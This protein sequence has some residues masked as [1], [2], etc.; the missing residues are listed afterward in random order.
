[1]KKGLLDF[2]DMLRKE[3]ELLEITRFVDPEL[4][5]A[6]ITD[7]ISKQPGGGKALFFTNTGTGYPLLIN[8]FGSERRICMALHLASLE[9]AGQRMEE[10][11]GIL[12]GQQKSFLGKLSLLPHL[13]EMSSWFPHFVKHRGA[14]QEIIWDVPDLYRLPVLKCW[15]NDAGRFI[16]LPVVH[17]YHPETRARNV[18]MYRMQVFSA[19]ATGMHWHRHKT[20]ATHYQAWK[21]KG[22]K[23]PVAVILGGDP[24]YTYVATAPLPEGIDEYLFAGFLRKQRVNL[25][26]CI[27]Q[28]IEVPEDAD[29]VIEGYV[30][31]MESLVPEGPFGDHTGFYS[32]QDFYPCFHVTAVTSRKEAV[33]PATVVGIPPQEDAWI[34]KA[35][36]RIFLKPI[37]IGLSPVI[38]DISLPSFGVAHNFAVVSIHKS[39]PG[40]AIKVANFLWGAGQMMLNKIMLVVDSKVNIHNEEEILAQLAS[41]VRIPEDFHFQMGPLDVLDHAASH[42][43]FGGKV[44]IDATTKMEEEFGIMSGKAIVSLEPGY[45]SDV[46]ELIRTSRVWQRGQLNVFMAAVRKRSGSI[47]ELASYLAQGHTPD[48]DL[49]ILLVDQEMNLTNIQS[50]L[51]YA[52]NNVDPERDFYFFKF[53]MGNVILVIDSTRKFKKTDNFERKWPNVITMDEKTIHAVDEKWRTLNLG[54]L[55]PSPSIMFRQLRLNAGAEV[56]DDRDDR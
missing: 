32:L 44:C 54:D 56:N 10:I 6:E 34:T 49:V 19:N 30:D 29:I 2:V 43:S 41:Q 3:H 25:V 51:W 55:I 21:E 37:Q 33:Y 42:F 50:V 27:T 26:K 13:A 35:T 22:Q 23:M 9:E 24:V 4:E 52:L 20:G 12:T 14:C 18:G 28:D 53:F 36:E 1:M 8:A 11:A 48:E 5:I 16:T 31:P 7:R 40:E 38:R 46:G 15:P 39:N 45:A 17:T 47:P